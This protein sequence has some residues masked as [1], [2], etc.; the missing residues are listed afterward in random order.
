[1][2]ILLALRKR[3]SE[4]IGLINLVVPSNVDIMILDLSLRKLEIK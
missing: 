2:K 3:N 1:M 4:T